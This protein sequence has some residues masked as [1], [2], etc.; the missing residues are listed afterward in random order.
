M[1]P[2][3]KIGNHDYTQWVAEGGLTPTDS[4]VD[5]SKSGRNTLDAVMVRNKLGHK[6]K[7]SVTLMDIPE[8]VAAQL[9]KDL[10]Q[11]FFS[12]TLLDPDRQS[13]KVPARSACHQAACPALHDRQERQGFRQ[14][15]GAPPVWRSRKG[16]LE[17]RERCPPWAGYVLQCLRQ[18]G[19]QYG[20]RLQG[21]VRL[22]RKRRGHGGRHLRHDREQRGR[23]L[24]QHQTEHCVQRE[25]EQCHA[26][27]TVQQVSA[28]YPRRSVCKSQG[29]RY[30]G[31]PSLC[32]F[33]VQ[34]ERRGRLHTGPVD[35]LRCGRLRQLQ[36][37]QKGAGP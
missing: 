24:F 18:G 26:G 30:D 32:R 10:S 31:V 15:R 34:R 12:A 25:H 29:A 9:S 6:M 28:V 19:P 13:G 22:H 11:T 21:Q 16:L 37:G 23:N 1:K 5:S 27:R 2:I 33:R 4:D 35:F 3:L 14:Q 36:K 7:W 17:E 8:E 20:H